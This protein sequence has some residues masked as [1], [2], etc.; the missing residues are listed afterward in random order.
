MVFIGHMFI[1]FDVNKDSN[2]DSFFQFFKLGRFGVDYFFVLSGF[3]ITW[4]GLVTQ[5][6][7]DVESVLLGGAIGSTN[8]AMTVAAVLL[9]LIL[10]TMVVLVRRASY[11]PEESDWYEEHSQ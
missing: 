6:F 1:F 7:F 10:A 5:A 4:N 11:E 2:Y 8:T 9:G 3:L